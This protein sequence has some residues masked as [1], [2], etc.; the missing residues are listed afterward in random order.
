MT[1][2]IML[3]FDTTTANLL[4]PRRMTSIQA[5]PQCVNLICTMHG[6]KSQNTPL[7]TDL[8]TD[9]ITDTSHVISILSYKI[10]TYLTTS[11]LNSNAKF[12][13]LLQNFHT[14]NLFMRGT[15]KYSTHKSFK[16]VD[17]ALCRTLGG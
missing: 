11:I 16:H 7:I 6:K 12:I 15:T 17:T 14:T 10:H 1:I 4:L 13:H 3:T 9:L 8:N 2:K 5:G